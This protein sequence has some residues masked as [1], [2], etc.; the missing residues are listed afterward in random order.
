VDRW[1]N[2][3]KSTLKEAEKLLNQGDD[4]AGFMLADLAYEDVPKDIVEE[5][6]AK[7]EQTKGTP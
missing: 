7:V 2:E 5:V 1:V 4:K 6:R 3:V